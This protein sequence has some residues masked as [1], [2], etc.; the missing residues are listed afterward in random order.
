MILEN[1]RRLYH[2][3]TKYFAKTRMHTKTIES[4]GARWA[5]PSRGQRRHFEWKKTQCESPPFLMMFSRW[6]CSIFGYQTECIEVWQYS[7][8]LICTYCISNFCVSSVGWG[9]PKL[10][11]EGVKDV[12]LPDSVK[13]AYKDDEVSFHTS[14]FY[15]SSVDQCWMRKNWKCP[16]KGQFPWKV[17]G[18]RPPWDGNGKLE[19]V[20]KANR[21][22]LTA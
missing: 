3:F 8:I 9:H 2:Y 17:S 15:F 10:S 6:I 12:L 1:L 7:V 13:K 21:N 20:Y 14:V 19:R 5:L 18:E 22:F 16:S 4:F 11:L